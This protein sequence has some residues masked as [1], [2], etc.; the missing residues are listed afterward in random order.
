MPPPLTVLEWG[1]K[2]GL[3]FNENPLSHSSLNRY[4][5]AKIQIDR[6]DR[7]TVNDRKPKMSLALWA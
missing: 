1:I 6:T 2:I 4:E 7:T 5:A 3:K